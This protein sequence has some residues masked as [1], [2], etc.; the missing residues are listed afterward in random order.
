MHAQVNRILHEKYLT[1][2]EK[3]LRQQNRAPSGETDLLPCFFDVYNGNSPTTDTLITENK[4]ILHKCQKT[5]ANP[6][7]QGLR[8]SQDERTKTPSLCATRTV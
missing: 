1:E 6:L 8:Q 7:L 2:P 3:H 4:M 5:Q